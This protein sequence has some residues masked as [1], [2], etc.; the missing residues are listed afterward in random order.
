MSNTRLNKILLKTFLKGKI[1]NYFR[2]KV[3]A[4]MP[5]QCRRPDQWPQMVTY[6]FF[7]LVQ[8]QWKELGQ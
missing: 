7:F 5:D 6:R 1:P 4:V 3:Q 2:G 8:L